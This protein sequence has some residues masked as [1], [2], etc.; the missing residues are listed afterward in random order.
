VDQVRPAGQLHDLRTQHDLRT[1]F[2]KGECPP[3]TAVQE[4]RRMAECLGLGGPTSR[5]G[6]VKQA[7]PSNP[8]A[9]AL[10]TK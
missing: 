2:A 8:F 6:R 3:I 7:E 10:E 1:I 4:C 5:V 9:L